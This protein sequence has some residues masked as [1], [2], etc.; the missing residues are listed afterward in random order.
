MK[1]TSTQYKIIYIPILY[2]IE[3]NA[4]DRYGINKIKEIIE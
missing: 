1:N 2:H 3:H 4:I